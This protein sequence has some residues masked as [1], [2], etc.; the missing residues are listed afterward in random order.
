MILSLVQKRFSV[1]RFE[2]VTYGSLNQRTLN[3]TFINSP[4]SSN[5]FPRQRKLATCRMI[6]GEQ[7]PFCNTCLTSWWPLFIRSITVIKSVV[8]CSRN[9]N[10]WSPIYVIKQK[11]PILL[12]ISE[13]R[14][15]IV[16]ERNHKLMLNKKKTNF[17]SMLKSWFAI[18]TYRLAFRTC[19]KLIS[20]VI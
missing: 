12:K 6:I 18:I 20:I 11:L 14:D 19:R 10:N 5:N 3:L 8:F 13:M 16:S 17:F 7:L 1:V 4:F 15:L 2:P 9:S